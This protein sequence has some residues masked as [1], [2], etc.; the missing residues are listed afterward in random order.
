[1]VDLEGIANHKGS[2]FGNIGMPSQPSQEMFE[3]RLA[4][5][6]STVNCQLSTVIW[7]E[8]ESQRIGNIN[9][10]GIFFKQMRA[11]HVWFLDIPFEERLKHIVSEYGKLEKEKMINAIVRIKKRLGGLETKNAIN[12][13]VEDNIEECFRILLRYYD[14]GYEKA[15]QT[16]DNW[17]QLVTK[18]EC[19]DCNAAVNGNKLMKIVSQQTELVNG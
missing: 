16:R 10:P 12:Y 11:K 6:L 2:A 1:V 4:Q 13:L 8:D 18:I 17:Q 14:K 5:Q 9:I 15:M 7:L 3:N 19:H